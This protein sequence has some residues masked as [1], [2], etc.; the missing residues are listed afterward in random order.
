MAQ[1]RSSQR[2]ELPASLGPFA[3]AFR[4]SPAGKHGAIL[5]RA[6]EGAPAPCR[7]DVLILATDDCYD[8]EF[9]V[10]E[11]IRRPFGWRA[12]CERKPLA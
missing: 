6:P 10:T 11:V 5:I 7:G 4:P 9:E 8:A 1:R 12:G 2:P 3:Y